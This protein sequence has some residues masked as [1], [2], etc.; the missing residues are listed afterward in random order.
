M[1]ERQQHLV[2]AAEAMRT[3]IHQQRALWAAGY[4]QSLRQAQPQYAA[5]SAAVVS[6]SAFMTAPATTAAD[7]WTDTDA[8]RSWRQGMADRFAST[9]QGTTTFVQT[10]WRML[11]G[12]AVVVI[13][14]GAV[15][16][17][18]PS[19]KEKMSSNVATGR[20]AIKSQTQTLSQK[21][22]GDRPSATKTKVAV[23][24]KGTGQ[25][26]VESSPTGARVLI[27]GKDRGVTPLTIDDLASGSHKVVIRGGDGS[28][29]RTVSITAGEL[30]QL[31][32]SIYSGWLHVT[33][34]FEFQI[35]EG[36]RSI[37]LDDSNQ[38]LLSPGPHDVRFENRTLGLREVRHLEIRPGET[39]AIS[40]ELPVS[41]LTVTSSEP[42]TVAIDGQQVGETPLTDYTVPVGTRDVTVTSASGQVRHQTITMKVQ[43]AQIDVDF[44]KP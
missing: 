36:R 34:P 44:S 1:D 3:W 13:L 39:T 24:A 29:Q 12:I 31:S 10:S 2:A 21:V 7:P 28:V 14:V 37:R 41:H 5:A 15:R 23:A 33:A 32:E 43:P 19:M 17:A 27:D 9:L 42:A 18:W 22:S 38:V 11:A 8:G 16:F 6:P 20:Q 35:S 4:P 25:L 30:L 26:Q 40:L